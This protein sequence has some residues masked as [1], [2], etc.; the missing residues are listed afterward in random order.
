[1]AGRGSLLKGFSPITCCKAQPLIRK[2]V[3]MLLI[4][5]MYL[6]TGD[7]YI[8]KDE[9]TTVYTSY[10][11]SQEDCHKA[12]DKFAPVSKTTFDAHLALNRSVK[13]IIRRV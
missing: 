10:G 2:L 9:Y 1:M 7:R 12:F 4:C 8:D 11:L 13:H 6:L 5:F 3:F